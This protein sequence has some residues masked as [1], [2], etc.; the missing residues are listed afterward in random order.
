MSTLTELVANL[1]E[2]FPQETISLPLFDFNLNA[3]VSTPQPKYLFRGERSADW[4]TSTSTFAREKILQRDDFAEINHFLSGRHYPTGIEYPDYHYSLYN[5]VRETLFDPN[6]L[7]EDA[8]SID[9]AIAGLMQHYGFDTAFLDV[10]SDVRI[11]ATFAATGKVG[12]RGQLM[13]LQ[14]EGLQDEYFDLSMLPGHRPK[15]QHAFALWGTGQLDLKS[16]DFLSRYGAKWF[17]F[18]LSEQDLLTFANSDIL[19]G[20]G[21]EVITIIVDW[22]DAHVRRHPQIS[23]TVVQYFTEKIEALKKCI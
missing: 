5:F 12:D 13:V 19:S 14:T 8:P 9:F 11:A 21:D 15:I 4:K 23:P 17:A 2:D 6:G 22:Y 10:T 20:A 3:V 18:T 7:H 1:K 16:A